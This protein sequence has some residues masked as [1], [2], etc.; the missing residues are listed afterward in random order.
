[1]NRPAAEAA[2]ANEHF[3]VLIVGAGLSGIGA[4]C[5]LQKHCPDRSYVV[6]EGRDTSGGTWDLFR[7][8]GVRS[9][10]DMYTLGYAFRPWRQPKSIAGGPAILEYLRDTATE[11]GIDRRIRFRHRVKRAAWSSSET[12]WT[13]EAEHDGRPVR[14][15]C[16]FLF[17]CSGYYNYAGGY[18]PEF[19][20]VGRFAGRI[21]HPQKWT[22]DIAYA[23]KRVLVIG[24]GAT[25]VTLVP[26][27]AKTAAHVVMLQRSPTWIVA[28]PSEDP[29]AKWLRR[30]LPPK[31][32]YGLTRWKQV[33]LQQYFFRL[34]RRNPARAKELI[35]SGVR[36]YLG[37]KYDVATHFTPRYNPW[38]QRLCLVPDA[39]LFT[40]IRSGKAS[41][42]TGEIDTFTEK[43]VR[44]KSGAELDADL[45]VTATGL[46]LQ[47]LGGVRLTVDGEP[48]EAPRIFN[49]KGLM[50]SDVPNLASVFGYTNASWTLKSDL[51]AQYVCRLLNHMQK[52][53][54]ARCTPRNRDGALGAEPWVDFSSGYIQRSLHLFPKQGAKAPWRLSQNYPRDILT[55]RF[56]RIDDGVMEFAS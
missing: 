12:K 48:V 53:G 47:V 55:L 34:C 39:D 24:S 29:F 7:Y 1:M 37:P 18:T 25:A 6:L 11:H 14:F 54:Y 35:L 32:A 23:G 27:L 20:G 8:P 45:V 22:G 31:I 19:P 33:L 42:L 40:A 50:Y 9:D 36:A 49:Y 21:V 44:L 38:E 51:A 41:V 43:G 2:L 16:G 17:L 10:S 4:G 52:H 26:E 3:D 5:H 46:D 15:T 56:G 28:R 13:V 30:W